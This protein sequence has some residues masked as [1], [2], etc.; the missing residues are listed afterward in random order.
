[1]TNKLRD[2]A[3]NP[4]QSFHLFMGLVAVLASCA[5]YADIIGWQFAVAF[6]TPFLLST[7]PIMRYA[8]AT[9]SN[10]QGGRD[11]HPDMEHDSSKSGGS[12]VQL[13]G[14]EPQSPGTIQTYSAHKL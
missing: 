2:E 10:V 7:A 9:T 14:L 12:T 4:M 1:M 11:T 5:C 3:R 8:A 6:V 13:S